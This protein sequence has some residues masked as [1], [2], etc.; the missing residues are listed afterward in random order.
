MYK[1]KQKIAFP[2]HSSNKPCFYL[3]DDLINIVLGFV[4]NVT[5]SELRYDLEFYR[6]WNETVP[7]IFLAGSVLYRD[8][9]YEVANPLCKHNPYVPRKYLS[10][11]PNDIW[12]YNLIALGAMLS[13]EK[14][15]E[16]RTYKRCAQRWI[17][18]CVAGNRPEYYIELRKKLLTRL[19]ISHF[20][21]RAP[22]PFLA[23]VFS[24]LAI[25]TPSSVS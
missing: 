2:E 4:W 8:F 14:I 25:Y 12:N 22:S 21:S 19:K 17:M 1:T 24:Q 7:P 5:A 6:R 9:W 15:R 13:R 18:D 20:Q 23:E 11:R 10:L 3:H 16:V